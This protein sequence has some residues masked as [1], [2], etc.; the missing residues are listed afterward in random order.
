MGLLDGH[1]AFV[2]G[3]GSGIGRGIAQGYSREGAKVIVADINVAGAEETARLVEDAGGEAWAIELDVANVPG[4][5]ICCAK[6]GSGYWANFC[7]GK[8]RWYC[9]AGYYR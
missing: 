7:V 3:G 5:P 1:L 4:C 9:E 8:Q 2:T 6:G